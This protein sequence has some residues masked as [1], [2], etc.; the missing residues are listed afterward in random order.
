MQ[1]GREHYE[2]YKAVEVPR[3]SIHWW[4]D[5]YFRRVLCRYVPGGRLLEIGCGT[6]F[7]LAELGRYFET[8]GIDTSEFALEHA[9]RNCPQADIRYMKGE[10]VATFAPESFDAVVARHVFEHM[11]EPGMVL[12]GC[13]RILKPGGFLLFIV[14]N[15]AS[16][17]RRWKGPDWYGNR[18]ETHISLLSPREWMDL[19]EKAGLAIKKSYSDGLWDAPYVTWL[20]SWVQRPLFGSLGGIQAL[21]SLSFMPLPLGEAL[22]VIAGKP[23]VSAPR[24]KR[25]R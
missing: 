9:R 11:R 16:I 12:E 20:P 8:C 7:F 14:P 18:D 10:D 13:Y 2:R 23:A 3:F 21:L 15:T 25:S 4:S 5:R 22:I 6:G 17:S 19:T 1:Y 24:W